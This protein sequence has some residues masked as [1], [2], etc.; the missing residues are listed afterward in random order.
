MTSEDAY[1]E[2]VREDNE[3]AEKEDLKK[4]KRKKLKK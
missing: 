3:V 1:L 2:S 4:A